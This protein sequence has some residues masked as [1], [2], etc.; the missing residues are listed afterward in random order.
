MAQKNE[1]DLLLSLLELASEHEITQMTA[2]EN[3]EEAE[4]IIKDR[5]KADP[6]DIVMLISLGFIYEKKNHIQ[7]AIELY[8]D[9]AFFMNLVQKEKLYREKN[10][11]FRS[12]ER[13]RPKIVFFVKPN[14]DT[15]IDPVIDHLSHSYRTVKMV[16]TD[17]KQIDKGMK[18]ADICWFEWCDNLIVY[19]SKL[20]LAHKKALI[21]RLHSYE[22]F[23]AYIYQVRWNTVD[24][25]IFDGKHMEQYVVHQVESLK[26][27]Q[28]AAIPNGVKLDQYT[29]K[30][31]EKGFH[32]AYVGYIN[33][34]KGPMLLLHAF[35]A[36]HDKDPR[37][38]LFIAGQY[39]DIR[40]QLY[41]K[42]MIEE[43]HLQ[44]SVQMDGWQSDINRY[45]E[46]KHYLIS[47]SLLE[48]QQMSVME[49]MAKGIKP[50]VHNFY[51]AKT[52]YDENFVWNTI[53]ELVDMVTEH[54]DSPHQYRAFIEEHYSFQKQMKK[55][56][57]TISRLA[58]SAKMSDRTAI[59]NLP[60]ITVGIVNYNYARFLDQC[61]Q[62][63]INQTYPNMEIIIVDDHSTDGSIEKINAFKEKYPHIKT[64]YHQ[65]NSGMAD[66]AFAEI[67]E[68]ATGE[69]VMP[70]SAD[71]FLAHD[72]VLCDLM[73]CFDEQENVDYVYGDFL[74]VDSD[75]KTIG[76]WTYQSYTDD[77]VIRRVFERGGSGVYPMVGLFK[78]SFY[79]NHNYSWVAD[80]KNLYAGDTLNSI[81]NIKRGWKY[82]YLNKP[83]YC[84]R[85]HQKSFT[86]NIDKRIP[87]IIHVMEYIIEHFSEDVY[88]PYINWNEL[89]ETHR[90]A[91]KYFTI[92]KIYADTAKDY[93]NNGFTRHLDEE[94]KKK[95]VRPLVEKMLSYFN[96][97]LVSGKSVYKKDIDHIKEEMDQLLISI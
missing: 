84:Y 77:E 2:E 78:L 79:R 72:S 60:K 24:Q 35:K 81:V 57:E 64:I 62:S 23:T 52:I 86:Y 16:V 75:G 76:S 13:V 67:F 46:D 58:K 48:S 32:I 47:T 71:D 40:Y 10:S 42:Q 19:G 56:E 36:I 1:L 93:Q 18:W 17:L 22:A 29:F 15:F 66:T 38:K 59:L 12:I 34:K 61:L 30:E 8:D 85:R 82:H 90:K 94:A 28:T 80:C 41:F 37:Y 63:V 68:E 95:C 92:G 43:L 44:D 3:W 65:E 5:L 69:Y 6:F 83:V 96:L 20:P 49:A 70:V 73:E 26:N 45:L 97:S 53:D 89:E 7:Q 25:V 91:L 11:L 50:L 74:L 31:R 39:Q 14:L 9:A 21:C 87:S 27:T 88:L 55:I 51:G 54:N 4:H 33:Y